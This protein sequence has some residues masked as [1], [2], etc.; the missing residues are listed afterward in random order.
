M[1]EK[2]YFCFSLRVLN[3]ASVKFG[4][5]DNIFSSVDNDASAG[6][7]AWL[8][9]TMMDA[10]HR[11]ALR[12]GLDDPEPFTVDDLMDELSYAEIVALKDIVLS[13][14]G[15]DNEA[16]VSVETESARPTGAR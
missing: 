15:N 9:A 8:A 1:G 13:T 5:V 11:Y 16:E 14:I 12:H 2:H 10:G 3:A 7:I 4:G 6:N